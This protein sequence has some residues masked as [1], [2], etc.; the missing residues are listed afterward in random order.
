VQLGP[1]IERV[2]GGSGLL[3]STRGD[4]TVD[5]IDVTMDS[6]AVIPGALFACVPGG[7]ADGHLFAPAAVRSGAVALLCERPLDLPVAQVVVTSVRRAI[8]PVASAVHGDPSQQL[9]VVGV[10][11]T[12]G[13][14][15]T[16]ALLSGILAAH[17]WPATSVGTLTQTR[18]TPEAPDLH[19]SLADMVASGERAVAMEVSSHALDQHRVDGVSFAAAIFTNLTQ[20]H[21]DYHQTMER[22]FEAKASL[23]APERTPVAVINR[24]DPW[25]RRLLNRV[26]EARAGGAAIELI[27]F[28]IDDAESLEMDV[29]G[30]R[31]RWQGQPVRLR[32]GGRFNVLNALGAARCALALGVTPEEVAQGLDQVESVAGRFEPVEA[33]QDFTVLVDYAH[34]PDGLG[35]ALAAARELTTGRLIIVFGAGGDRDH[36]KRH[37]MGETAARLADLAIVTSDNPR[38]E[39]PVAIIAQVMA[40]V[41]ESEQAT[42]VEDRADAI[43][44]ALF[45]AERGDV[46]VIAGKGHEKVQEIGG[47]IRPFDDA[48]V[49]RRA[50]VRLAAARGSGGESR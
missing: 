14:T 21:L 45:I 1:L 34:T 27:D 30:S 48:E 40:G 19:R 10:T 28:G 32:I 25:G 16:C 50:L 9:V 5:V 49:A 36:D 17:G 33:G 37:L 7:R 11:G 47:R 20:D 24:D 4:L 15:T 29:A 41:A 38:S 43:E 3:L 23:F 42:I 39:D 44:T 13:K 12:N 22:Y 6:R 26:A 2:L 8:G 46:V 31:F 18:T 35:K